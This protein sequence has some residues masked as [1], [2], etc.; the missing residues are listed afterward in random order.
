[1]LILQPRPS[2]GGRESNDEM[3]ADYVPVFL[4]GVA[5]ATY[6][7]QLWTGI[8]FAGWASENSLIERATRP[9]PY[10]FVMTLQTLVLIVIPLL[11]LMN[12]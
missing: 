10:W 8:A 11:L 6:I 9:G 4:L 1:M 12:R 7:L 3:I 2:G 5:I